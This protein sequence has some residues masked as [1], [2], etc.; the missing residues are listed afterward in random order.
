MNLFILVI[1]A[2]V[3]VIFY[4]KIRI[5]KYSNNSLQIDNIFKKYITKSKDIVQIGKGSNSKVVY[6][7]NYPLYAFKIIKNKDLIKK[8]NDEI[9]AYREINQHLKFSKILSL[10]NAR[11]LKFYGYK[12][13]LHKNKKLLIIM[14]ERVVF[15]NQKLT[16][17]VRLTDI[18][19]FGEMD[20]EGKILNINHLKKILG[21][22]LNNYMNQLGKLFATFHYI[23]HHNMDDCEI[24]LGYKNNKYIF[25]VGDLDTSKYIKNSKNSY[26]ILS[27]VKSIDDALFF[28][29]ESNSCFKSFSKGY[30]EISKIVKKDQNAQKV[31]RILNS[32]IEQD[33]RH[34]FQHY[35]LET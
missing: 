28:R 6:D 21:K 3:I 30:L 19:F 8:N 18:S 34:S 7:V 29:K 20:D 4:Q 14:L 1:I 15:G 9:K 33:F 10:P 32:F 2:V 13:Y 35:L 12:I 16:N 17:I 5:E 31:L 26:S 27:M 11:L 24:Y 25:Y 22:N 23:C